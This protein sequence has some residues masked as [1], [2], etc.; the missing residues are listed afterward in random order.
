MVQRT[1]LLQRVSGAL[2]VING[3]AKFLPQPDAVEQRLADL[4]AG[5]ASAARRPSRGLLLL[6]LAALT[7]L[8][9]YRRPWARGQ[10]AFDASADLGQD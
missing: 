7:G 6:T 1:A 9:F 8:L 5:A 2:Y 3:I 4:P 10:A